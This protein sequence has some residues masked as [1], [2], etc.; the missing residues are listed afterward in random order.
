MTVEMICADYSCVK[1][2]T[3]TLYSACLGCH[4]FF[5]DGHLLYCNFHENQHCEACCENDTAPIKDQSLHWDLPIDST[6]SIDND[7]TT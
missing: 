1:S 4:E 7:G 6:Q 3:D 2:V 5:C